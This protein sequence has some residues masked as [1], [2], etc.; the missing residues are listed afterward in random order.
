MSNEPPQDG[1]W[2][3]EANAPWTQMLFRR[4]RGV[5]NVIKQPT[6]WRP[7]SLTEMNASG[8]G[9]KPLSDTVSTREEARKIC[10]SL[11]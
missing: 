4:G 3:E 7:F 2:P 11:A 8:T 9:G 6:G 10:E 1:W 5:A